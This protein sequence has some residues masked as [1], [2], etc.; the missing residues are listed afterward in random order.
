LNKASLHSWLDKEC[1]RPGADWENKIRNV[2]ENC[3][4]FIAEVNPF[5]Q[6][7]GSLSSLVHH[8]NK[9]I[10]F[11]SLTRGS[12]TTALDSVLNLYAKGEKNFDIIITDLSL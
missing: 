10:K 11:A 3:R 6:T 8:I 1:L 12:S 9:A 7:S 5:E 2:R 4:Y